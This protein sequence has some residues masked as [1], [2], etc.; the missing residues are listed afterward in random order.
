MGGVEGKGVM[1]R[2][3]RGKEGEERVRRGPN[4]PFIASQA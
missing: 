4:S 3:K 2:I 1:E